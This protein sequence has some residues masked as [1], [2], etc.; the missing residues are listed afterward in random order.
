MKEIIFF[1]H[2]AV[3]SNEVKIEDNYALKLSVKCQPS[4]IKKCLQSRKIWTETCR[5]QK[6]L[7]HQNSLPLKILCHALHTHTN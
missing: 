3:V 2:A 5:D 4:E 6:N 7:C 1:F